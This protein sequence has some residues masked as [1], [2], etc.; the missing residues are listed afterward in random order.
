MVFVNLFFYILQILNERE[1]F[2]SKMSTWQFKIIQTFIEGQRGSHLLSKEIFQSTYELLLTKLESW[3]PDVIG[4]IK[5]YLCAPT[6]AHLHH[7][8]V[9]KLYKLGSIISFYDLP[10][11]VFNCV[12]FLGKANYIQMLIENENI[13]LETKTL[14]FIYKILNTN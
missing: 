13:G 14:E 9:D 10:I 3:T 7:T 2:V 4:E 5:Q 1:N 11:N 6:I 8:T 12:N